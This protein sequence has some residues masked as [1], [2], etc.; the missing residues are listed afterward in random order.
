MTELHFLE[1]QSAP[2][3]LVTG[4]GPGTGAALARRFT[5][6]GYRCALMARDVSRL[7]ALAAEL[8]GALVVPCDVSDADALAQAHA[9]IVD[10]LGPPGVVLHNAVL[11]ARGDFLTVE[12][13]HLQRALEVN[14][15]GLL[16]VARLC[17]PA[18]MAAGRGAI[19]VTGNTSAHR[20]RAQF[21]GLAPTKAAQRILAESMARRLGPEGVH[22]SYLTIDAVIDVPWTR[23]A[24]AGKPDEFYARPDDLAEACWTLAHQPR[25]AWTFEMAVRPFG[26]VW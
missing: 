4:V 6:G 19:V 20:G 5:A 2:V 8:P 26:E 18:M 10:Q 15:M 1:S 12:P 9:R 3:A 21:A 16:H 7:D 11:G 14:V 22:V 13:R 24:Y 23:E 25:S 17:A